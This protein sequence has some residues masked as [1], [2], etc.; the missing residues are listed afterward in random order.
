MKPGKEALM[1]RLRAS[2][3]PLALVAA[4]MGLSLVAM[5][6]AL[7]AND[8]PAGHEGHA[9]HADHA[10]HAAKDEHAAH[11]QH[12]GHDPHAAH[13]AAAAQ[14]K[15]GGTITLKLADTVLKDQDG[16][17]LRLVSDLMGQRVTVVDFIYTTCTT[18]CPVLSATM[19]ELQRKLGARV[20]K[21][22]QLVSITVDPLRDTP[23][24]LKAYSAKHEAGSGWRWL[25]GNKGDVDSVLKTFGAYSTDPE[26]HPAMVMIGDGE[27]RTWTRLLGFP[28]VGELQAQVDLALSNR[29]ARQ[30]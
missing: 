27:G 25:T 24:R 29:A 17:D 13:W 15:A 12:A 26:S 11:G 16:R 21:D 20:G 5:G 10:M 3:A 14:G 7:A 6:P 28:S 18:V 8:M 1:Q 23:A 2:R 9:M 19:A 22:V 30:H 4:V